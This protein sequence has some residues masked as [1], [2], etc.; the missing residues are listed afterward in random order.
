MPK[1][2]NKALDYMMSHRPLRDVDLRKGLHDLEDVF[3]GI[4]GKHASD[5][6]TYMSPRVDSEALKAI[7]A[8]K[9]NP[10]ALIDIYR[11][12]PKGVR[13]I[14]TGDWVSTSKAYAKGHGESILD[15][16]YDLLTA[17]AKA[18]D[19]SNPGDSIA[20][21]G[22]W[23]ENIEGKVIRGLLAMFAGGGAGMSFSK[24]AQAAKTVYQEKASV[25][26]SM[27]AQWDAY[28]DNPEKPL[29]S[30]VWSPIDLAVAPIGSAS[31]GAKALAVALDPA[32]SIAMDSL[33]TYG[34]SG[35][36]DKKR[37]TQILNLFN[38][39]GNY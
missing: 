7:Y 11:A 18:K 30:P 23:G 25:P 10:E 32:L 31:A 8:A 33:T 26:A 3:P 21:E 6:K 19:I 9:G 36:N 1:V 39:A 15:G 5:Y 22:Y 12:V 16:K 35:K 34:T 29:E 4:Y 24:D 17:K 2:L 37:I 20:E 13:A 27:Q 14:N 38:G 28:R